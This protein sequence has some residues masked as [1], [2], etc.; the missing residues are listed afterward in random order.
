MYTRNFE[1][2]CPCRNDLTSLCP[3]RTSVI[4][5]LFYFQFGGD[6]ESC[7]FI[8]CGASWPSHQPGPALLLHNVTYCCV[9]G[10]QPLCFS[11]LDLIFK[12]LRAIKRL[13]YQFSGIPSSHFWLSF[14]K[15]VNSPHVPLVTP[16]Q[17]EGTCAPQSPSM[18]TSPSFPNR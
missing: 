1:F 13:V 8:H 12:L 14:L 4:H 17:R 2:D 7:L 3:R 16:R 9:T 18:K 11:S 5:L 10:A 15:N 6:D